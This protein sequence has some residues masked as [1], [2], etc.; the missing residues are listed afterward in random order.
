MPD[1]NT[2]LIIR[3]SKSSPKIQKL[4]K[5]IFF[6]FHIWKVPHAHPHMRPE[7]VGVRSLNESKQKG[8]MYAS[9][10]KT[11]PPPLEQRQ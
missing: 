1:N 11:Q 6:L 5:I 9:G 10:E 2:W 3:A 7:K 8:N 4:R